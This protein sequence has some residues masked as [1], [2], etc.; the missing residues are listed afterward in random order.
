MILDDNRDH[1][2]DYPDEI[3]SDTEAAKYVDGIALHWYSDYETTSELLS[4]THERHP[5]KFILYTE[6]NCGTKCCQ[7]SFGDYFCCNA[8]DNGVITRTR[9]NEGYVYTPSSTSWE[10]KFD[11]NWLLIGIA[12]TIILSAI[13]SLLCCLLCN[14]CDIFSRREYTVVNR[15]RY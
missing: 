6:L 10:L 12:I 11:W 1:L 14:G 2:P 7:S 13:L 8:E 5:D 4:I 15:S 9:Q 3:L